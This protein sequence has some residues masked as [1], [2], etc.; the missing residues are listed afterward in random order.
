MDGM[1]LCARFTYTLY[2]AV[3]MTLTLI[4][5]Y[6]FV[7]CV[8][9]KLAARGCRVWAK[10]I[11]RATW[12]PLTTVGLEH[13]TKSSPAIYVA[14]HA[15]YVDSVIILSI[16]PAGTRFVGKKELFSVPILRTFMRQLH[17]FE[18]DRM[19]LTK[20]MEDTQHIES[21]LID[22]HSIIIFPEGTFS[23]SS[24]LRPF[25]LGAFKM[26]AET[27][28]SVCPIALR[29]TRNILRAE[30]K[31]MCPGAITVTVCEPIQPKGA[32]WQDVTRLRNEA[33]NQIAK[34]CGEPSLDFIAAQT[35]A[36]RTKKN[37]LI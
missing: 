15:S 27:H 31:L 6:F 2:V 13:I 12:C 18:L 32:E 10:L 3:I 37:D 16:V 26:A 33:R 24:G 35:V 20:G 9:T 17:Y 36:S 30:D 7:R 8:P 5:L 11:V 14:N 25:R 19:D 4:P 29:G 28:I 34:Y 23:Y 1:R 22:G 21:T